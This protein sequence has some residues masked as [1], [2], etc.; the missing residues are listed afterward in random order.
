MSEELTRLA[1][2][3]RTTTH[4]RWTGEYTNRHFPGDAAECPMCDLGVILEALGVPVVKRP[5]HGMVLALEGRHV[6]EWLDC[7]AVYSDNDYGG[8]SRAEIADKLE[9]GGYGKP[10]ECTATAGS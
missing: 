5:L 7:G 9:R 4:P 2:A 3:L 1:N 10:P 6:P 8:L